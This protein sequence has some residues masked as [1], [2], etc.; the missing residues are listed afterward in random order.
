LNYLE[1]KYSANGRFSE[2]EAFFHFNKDTYLTILLLR[3]IR[4]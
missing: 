3:L 4:L 1:F 2:K